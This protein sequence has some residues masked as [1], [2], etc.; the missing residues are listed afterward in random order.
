MLTIKLAALAGVLLTVLG[1]VSTYITETS[2]YEV[3]GHFLSAEGV[4]PGNDVLSSGAKIGSVSAVGLAPDSDPDG[5]ALVT[6]T[7]DRRYAPLHQGS[8]AVIREKGFL[9]N[10]YVELTPGPDGNRAIRSGGSIPIQDTAAPVDLDQVLDIFDQQTREKIKIATQQ[11]GATFNGNGENLNHILADLPQVTENLASVARNIDLADRE[12]DALTVEFD[13]VAQMM[14]AEDQALRGDIAN[15]ASLLKSIAAR[16]SRLQQE[17]SEANRAL[18]ALN[19]ALQGHEKD[20][21]V[22]LQAMPALQDR[23]RQLS[24]NS[25]PVLADINMCYP[26]IVNAVGGLRSSTDYKHPAGSQDAAG[27]ELRVYTTFG[28]TNG[29]QGQASPATATCKGGTPSG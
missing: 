26:D 13:R 23:L 19:G 10:M 9:G 27:F 18:G 11:G 21:A 5:G 1:G 25:D 4:V 6:M 12:L 3:T 2:P 20:L 22:L 16:E 24:Q 7:I 15:G 28:Q 14:A 29:V 17:I 8:K